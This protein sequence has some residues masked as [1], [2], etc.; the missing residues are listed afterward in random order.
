MNILRGQSDD[1]AY[2][3]GEN[4]RNRGWSASHSISDHR[5]R[6]NKR[7]INGEMRE[8]LFVPNVKETPHRPIH[9]NCATR[10]LGKLPSWSHNLTN[11]FLVP[12]LPN[13]H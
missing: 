4:A 11:P 6:Q 13:H 9:G 12:Q 3:E 7:I 2:F 10:S 1:V 8:Y 5:H